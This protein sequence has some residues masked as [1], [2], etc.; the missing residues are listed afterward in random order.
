MSGPGLV[1]VEELLGAANRD[2]G[3]DAGL[4]ASADGAEVAPPTCVSFLPPSGM[5][6]S[7]VEAS[8][9]TVSLTSPSSPFLIGVSDAL[10]EASV[11]DWED[12]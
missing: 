10:R 5:S 11:F 8:V 6:S 4:E 2:A 3:R 9:M 12:A 1:G 7:L